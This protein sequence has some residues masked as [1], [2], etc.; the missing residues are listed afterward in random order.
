MSQPADQ[1][2]FHLGFLWVVQTDLGY[3]GGLLVTNQL[4]RPLEFQCTTPIRPN[5]TQEILYG[6][7][8]EPFVY[9]ELIGKTLFERLKVQPELVII[10]QDELIDLRMAIPVPVGCLVSKND[11]QQ[12]L[13]DQT[14]IQLGMQQLRFHRDYAGD[15]DLLEQ[16]CARIS[17]DADLAEP[18]ERV[19]DA[20][21]ETVKSNAV[22]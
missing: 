17:S 3:V 18:L 20:L 7:T 11:P 10:S 5:K 2:K 19:K 13:P 21:L 9:S 15:Q 4:G 8:L 22:A 12:D 14:R 16:K 6:P 1:K